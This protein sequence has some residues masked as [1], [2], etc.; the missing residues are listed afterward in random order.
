MSASAKPS[1]AARLYLA[2]IG[3][4]LALMGGVFF[5][6]MWRSFDRARHM[7]SWPEVRCV[8]IE[9]KAEERR[10]DPNSPAEYRV[11]VTYGYEFNGQ[12]RT[13]DHMT[14]RGNPWTSKPDVIQERLDAFKEG[15]STTCRVDPQ[16]PDFS[17]LKPDTKAP[18][19]SIWFPALFVAGGLG[20]TVRA[21]TAGRKPP[22][23]A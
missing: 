12:A 4:S 8:I 7:Q 23:S 3:L 10:I 9:S 20:I 11:N 2:A 6:L 19:Y 22:E 15:T 17:V 5:W 13:G 21:F 1:T 18:G 16:N 14:W